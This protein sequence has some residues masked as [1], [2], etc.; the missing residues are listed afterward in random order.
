MLN[1]IQQ[2]NESTVDRNTHYAESIIIK[3]TLK[4]SI[5]IFAVADRLGILEKYNIQKTGQIYLGNCPTG[6]ASENHQCFGLN[7]E[8]NYF[9]CF[10]CN[11]AGDIISLV[12]L[13]RQVEYK[14]ALLWLAE[15]FLHDLAP[16]IQHIS[17]E[18]NPD[19]EELYK[20]HILYEEIYKHGKELLYGE[21][22]KTALEALIGRGY[23]LEYLQQTEW[24]YWPSDGEIR[25]HLRSVRP[26]LGQLIAKLSLNG[27]FGD[28]FRMAFPYRNRHGIITGFVKR[29]TERAGYTGNNVKQVRYDSTQGLTK[30]D[31]FGLHKLH[32]EKTLLI[33]EGYPDALYLPALGVTNIVAVGQGMLAESHIEGLRVRKMEQVVLAL[34]NDKAGPANTEK[35]LEML[36]KAGIDAYVIDPALYGSYKDP[37]EFVCATGIDSFKK[38]A[39]NPTSGARWVAKRVLLKHDIRTDTGKKIALTEAFDYAHM[40]NNPIDGKDIVDIISSGLNMPVGMLEPYMKDYLDKKAQAEYRKQAN[41][42]LSKAGVLLYKDEIEQAMEL[43][44]DKPRELALAYE[45]TR[46]G[47]Q[48]SFGMFLR[49]KKE[50]DMQKLPGELLGYDLKRFKNISRH[51][52]GVQPGYYILGADPNTGKTAFMVNLCID[53]L[54]MNPKVKVFFYSMDDDRG[55]IVNRMLAMLTH[56]KINAVQC[57]QA[58]RKDQAK[59]DQAYDYLAEQYDSARLTIKDIAELNNVDDIEIEIRKIKNKEHLVVFVD[60]LYNMNVNGQ[61]KSVREENIKRAMR[62]KELTKAYN[63]P[64]IA[65]A[66][67]RKKQSTEDKNKKP[68]L[69]DIMESGKYAYNADVVWM[70]S[71][72]DYATYDTTDEPVVLLK[73]EKNK[74]DSFR[75]SMELK[76]L[77]AISTMEE[78][79]SMTSFAA[80]LLGERA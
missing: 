24:I 15:N 26:E 6:H 72:Q 71:P 5:S 11:R 56:L 60:G 37:D 50:H 59:I 67:L 73:F 58:D 46:V 8:R 3:D 22:G 38:L 48:E 55:T 12:Q 21:A 70:L 33:V 52:S 65:T 13:V 4:D 10:H 7:T 39:L 44:T 36:A 35:A 61:T 2:Q 47:S 74:L 25:V 78:T 18:R 49:T 57:K 51:L 17:F 41:K 19:E 20:K 27:S 77:R 16:E 69:Q 75:G 43:L 30:H 29:S 63:I 80:Q 54:Q 31:L 32:H 66:E 34:D 53:L 23:K 62:M 14:Q 42:L 9:H 1:N 79:Q 64:L 40:V 76:F 68:T 28:H 45:R